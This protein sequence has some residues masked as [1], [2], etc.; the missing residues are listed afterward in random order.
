MRLF[1]I[2]E[3]KFFTILTFYAIFPRF[4]ARH[5]R[6]KKVNKIICAVRVNFEESYFMPAT[7]LEAAHS[8]QENKWLLCMF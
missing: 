4:P 8:G 6:Q 1:T 3:M 7:N 2:Y 5:E